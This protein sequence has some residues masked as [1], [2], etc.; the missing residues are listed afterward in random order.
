MTRQVEFHEGADSYRFVLD[1][2]SDTAFEIQKDTLVFSASKFY[3]CFF[4]GLTEKPIYELCEPSSELKGQARHVF[5]TVAT[6]F[7][8]ACDSIDASWFDLADK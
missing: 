6:I 7:Q 1:G 2:R 5:E 4:K 8:E 3:E